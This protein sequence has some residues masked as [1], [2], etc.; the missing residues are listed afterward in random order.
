LALLVADAPVGAS[1][2]VDG[3][4]EFDAAEEAPVPMAF[5]AFTLKV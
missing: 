3:V 4:A 5:V 2:T 1:G